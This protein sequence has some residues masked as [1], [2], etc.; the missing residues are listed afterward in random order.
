[1]QAR[2]GAQEVVFH[3]GKAPIGVEEIV[4][5]HIDKY[6]ADVHMDKYQAY[7]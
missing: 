2:V 1:M 6:Q 7:R 3:K 5:V 4:C